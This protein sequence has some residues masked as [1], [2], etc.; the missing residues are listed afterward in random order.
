M[1]G[2]TI[3]HYRILEKLGGGG[4]GVVYKAEDTRL[5]RF[6][7]LKFLPEQ[8]TRD[9]AALERF[10][11][12]AQAASALDHPN[13][14]TIY[15]IGEV[16]GRA[17]EGERGEP[18]I[19]MQFLDG[20]TLKHRIASGALKIDD[21]LELAIE[22]A[23]G[24]DAAHT[25][26]IVHR[27]IKPAN[28]FITKAGHAKILDFGLA[29]LAPTRHVG[30][31][32]G[33]TA[34]AMATA[35]G[36]E[37]LTS[38][39]T[40]VG[41]IAY[42]S[43]EQVRGEDLDARTDLFSFG[44]V[45][46]EMVTG[47]MAFTGTT[48][49]VIHDAILNRSPIPPTR[50][51]PAIP[52]E[53]ER[54]IGRALEKDRTLRY[55]HASDL[56]AEL[57][58]LKR[59]TES[60]QSSATMSVRQRP[61]L[62]TARGRRAKLAYGSVAAGL[63]LAVG[64]GWY[65]I[66]ARGTAQKKPLTERQ[67]T[68]N[69]PENPIW[70]SAIS[71]DG[72]HVAYADRV[73]VH[74]VSLESGDAHDVALPEDL[75]ADILYLTW[76]PDGERLILSSCC[77]HGRYALWLAS[78]FGGAPRKLRDDSEGASVS[79]DG[80]SIL[81][82]G[83]YWKE[84]WVMAADGS[85][86]RKIVDGL[87]LDYRSV[88]W[89]PG[90]KRIAYLRKSQKVGADSYIGGTIETISLDG[91]PPS[92]VLSDPGLSLQGGLTWLHDGRMI[93]VSQ[94]SPLEETSQRG[95]WA[96][97]A[98]VHTGSPSASPVKIISWPSVAPIKLSISDDGKR[99]AVG[100]LRDWANMYAGEI[101]DNGTRLDSP[102]RLTSNE[103][104]NYPFAWDRS[105]GTILFTSDRMGGDE[106]FKQRLGEE[107]AEPVV[108]GQGS[109]L[110]GAALS[111]DSAWILYWAQTNESTAQATSK[112]LMRFPTAGGSPDLVLEA[113][114]AS[115]VDISCP[116]RLPRP[117]LIS[118]WE[119]GQLIFYALDPLQ[120]KG[121]EVIRTNLENTDDSEWT[122]SPD[123]WRIAVASRIQLPEKL[124]ILDLRN[125]SERDL[126]LSQGSVIHSL[127]WA[128]DN[129]ALFATI[130]SAE[131]R[132]ERVALDGKTQ[133]LLQSNT[134]IG[135]LLASPDDRY[136]AY[137]QQTADNNVWLLENF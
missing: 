51:N 65:W 19:A 35:T 76:A 91:G 87:R 71:P 29:K 93:Y 70:G 28:I 49:G 83:N 37:L 124:R 134:L 27:D 90:G 119:Q 1:I 6:V 40:A 26:G 73:G 131:P 137:S 127:C 113:P 69:L 43:P 41:T 17:G 30:E 122:L 36:D 117:C 44:A 74:V 25:K 98:D 38:P 12:E 99:L 110:R 88:A 103:S 39:G 32:V 125:G 121:R 96:I 106:I 24:L 50:L 60:G 89:S 4:M 123:G 9:R 22:I 7:A 81:F 75:R 112:K 21:V 23:D 53:L 95:L 16:P 84:I 18:F 10:E 101:K 102:K 31:A 128:A 57:K 82:M 79:P 126:Q 15:E 52:A 85:S 97:P 80:S 115:I 45:L 14:C 111:P 13:I 78:I 105:S 68:F 129:N 100:K 46:Y 136:L 63:L 2:Q 109:L 130:N 114:R 104:V 132:I 3:S 61:E 72:K 8:M 108:K 5:H 56:R 118:E 86:A 20:A 33:A 107:A 11:R 92:V 135:A 120:G 116:S 67:I 42:M 64:L 54:I 58:R 47:H 48:P 34:P 133:V 59:E 66:K 77:A 62:P 55:Q 94:E